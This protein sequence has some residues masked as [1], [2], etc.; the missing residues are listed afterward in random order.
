MSK[1]R[2]GAAKQSS[3]GPS[4]Q[5]SEPSH[6]QSYFSA[7]SIRETVESIVVAFVLAFLFRTFEAEA[8][9]IPTGSMAPTLMGAHKD[10]PCPQ[11]GYWFRAGASSEADDVAQQR[12]GRSPRNE[13]VA[14]TC[15]MCRHVTN[16]DPRSPE[17]R[18][19][20]TYG[21]DRIL[22]SKFTFDF[23]E[24]R[25]WDVTVFKY[26]GGAE[27][28]YIKRL[29]GLPRETVRLWHGDLHIKPP[30]GDDFHLQRRTP[31]ELRAMTQI[32][33]DNDYVDDEMTEKG[34]PVRWQPW[35]ADGDERGA[36]TTDDGSRSY[37]VDGSADGV[38][39]L[40][41]QHFTPSLDDWTLLEEGHLPNGY[42][43]RPRLI[44][45]FYAYDTSVQRDAPRA[46]PRMLG[47]H[48]VGDLMLEC[49]LDVTQAYGKVLLELVEGGRHFRCQLDCQSGEAQLSI[50]ALDNYGP[51]AQTAVQGAGSHTVALANVDDQLVLW[52]DG[53]PV[54][55]DGPTTYPPLDNDR[56]Q[57]DS[58]EPGD[59]LPARIG[60]QGAGLRV[61]HL[62]LSRDIYYIAAE[63][64]NVSDYGYPYSLIT[65]L[66]YQ[67][68]LRFRSTPALW[69]D[70]GQENPFDQRREVI[71]PLGPDQFFMLGDNSPLSQD[72]RLWPAE[73]Y[74]ERRLLVGKALYIFWP[75]SFDRIPGTRIPFPFFPNFARM[76][77]IR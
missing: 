58:D 10:L 67:E 38:R 61:N 13:V 70:D 15:P 5:T 62:R 55:F 47:L 31:R 60:S 16:V 32:V 71:F 49:E 19:Y 45:D 50:D 26:P 18:E 25:R 57:S 23:N 7:A 12:G 27:T 24:P 52:I 64:R 30:G 41:Y 48:W 22:V 2:S 4:S 77:F 11:C 69:F 46:Q 65:Q 74:V 21:G 73:P 29:V 59:L 9:V 6:W 66:S 34:W 20:P 72:A 68:L 36:W 51:K 8:F 54:E 63:G 40:G 17:G 43:P 37:T 33:Y 56:P 14:V 42:T 44:T 39:W 3:S 28:N 1:K 76:R 35:P 75:H 53:S